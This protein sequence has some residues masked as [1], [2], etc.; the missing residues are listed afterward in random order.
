ME[1]KI[2]Q[3]NNAVDCVQEEGAAVLSRKKRK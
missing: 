3:M 1:E 2:D